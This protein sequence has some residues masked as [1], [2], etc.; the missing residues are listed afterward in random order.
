[1]TQAVQTHS[2]AALAA[3]PGFSVK[4]LCS[5]VNDQLFPVE[6]SLDGHTFQN[7]KKTKGKKNYKNSS[8]VGTVQSM[9]HCCLACTCCMHPNSLVAQC[10]ESDLEAG[11]AI[12]CMQSP[13]A[14]S[15]SAPI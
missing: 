2:L 9:S 15:L 8:C 6:C 12:T 7:Q 13:S 14:S 5:S 10:L 1:M 4:L 11:R 3:V